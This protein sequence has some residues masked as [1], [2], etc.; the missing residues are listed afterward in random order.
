MVVID[1]ELYHIGVI[2]RSGRYPWGSGENPFQRGGDFLASVQALKNKGLSESQIAEG[3]GITTTQL[4]AAKAIAKNAKKQA[5]ISM[6][7]RMKESGMSNVAIGEQMGINE[8]SVRALLAPAAQDRADILQA[9]SNALRS[10]VDEKGYIDVGRGIEYGMGVSKEK[11][12]TAIAML[13]AEGYKIHYVKV[14]QLGTGH[15]TTYKVLSKPDIPY[16][17]VFENQDKI[18]YPGKY[19]EDG[20]RTYLGMEPPRSI[21]SKRVAVRYAED[22][23]ADADGVIYIRP[24]VDDISLGGARYAQVRMAVDGTHYLKGMAVYKDDMP[25]GVDVIFNTNKKNTGD[26]LAAMKQMKDDPDNPFGSVVRQ[27]HYLGKNGKPELSAMNI[28]NEEGDWHK[29]G[30]TLSSQMLSKQSPKLAKEQLGMAGDIRKQELD[31]ILALNNPTVRK[32]LLES[33]A[34]GA[35]AA[36]S[37][38]KA[39]GL[40]RTRSQVILPI[41]SLKDGEI[42]APNYRNGERVALV[43]H[44]HGGKFEIPELTVNNRNPEGKSYLGQAIDA[45]GINSKV[46]QRL[47][48]ADFD[49]DTVLVI[50]NNQ[51]KVKSQSPLAGLKDFDPQSA[52]PA[53]EGMPRM[54]AKTKQRQM[55]DVSNLIT[56]MSIRG[57]SNDEIA[58]A[59]RHSMVVIDAEKHNLN[60]KQSAADNGIK[61]LKQKYQGKS[62]AG[63]STLVSRA[64][65]EDRVP[66]RTPRSFKDGGPVDKAT[67]RKVYS[68]TGSSYVD[69]AG[70]T[71][72]RTTKV[73]RMD[74]TD[75]AY[76][77]SSGTPMEAVYA[78]H[79]NR[80]KSYSNKARKAAIDTPPLSYSPEARKTYRPQVDTLRAKLNTALENAPRERQAQLVANA[81]VSEKRRANPDMT[82]ADIKKVK[83]QALNEARNRTGA[84]KERVTFTDRE[85]RAIQDGAISNSFLSQLL[86]NAD[87]DHVKQLSTPKSVKA[88]PSAKLARAKNML[89]AGY[90]QSEI[91]DALG[92]PASTL[93]DSLLAG[94]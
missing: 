26:K 21:S 43:R 3:L 46:A 64:S 18:G 67:G 83:S 14:A 92:V 12:N 1:E 70:R 30:K 73:K 89:S 35:D 49:G 41:S 32:K 91:A 25:D 94:D 86:E 78:D 90:T 71:V 66:E 23:G 29:W 8:S 47:S 81:V 11:L 39:T 40:P 38:L 34:D 59:V 93:N 19:S 7:T 56:D 22:G 24:G 68:E 13:E 6:A 63:A 31:D 50:P 48:G 44:P 80:L 20:G 52:Y 82:P 88:I 72:Q 54:S 65:S 75:D 60:Y 53:Y 17:E 58:R 27:R 87:M 74:L 5:D 15:E 42:Y 28:V 16:R 51:G 4:R 37:S 79:A 57:A 84:K 62:N 10:S 9:T 2:R 61:Q 85:W 36:A 45:V 33:Y 69:K 77:L 55:G 76:S